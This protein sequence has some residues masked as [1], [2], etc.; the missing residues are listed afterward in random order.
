M[1]SVP[2]LL[3]VLVGVTKPVEVL[4]DDQEEPGNVLRQHQRKKQDRSKGRHG[5][6]FI[7]DII[8]S[9]AYLCTV[10]REAFL[11]GKVLFL[12]FAQI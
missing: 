9:I 10:L 7:G 2:A 8:G 6:I 4:G 11:P 1:L 3:A 5:D 12:S